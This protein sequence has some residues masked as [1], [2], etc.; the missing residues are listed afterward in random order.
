MNKVTFNETNKEKRN[1]I[2]KETE[3]ANIK[4]ILMKYYE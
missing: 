3:L 4:R 2:R 1:I